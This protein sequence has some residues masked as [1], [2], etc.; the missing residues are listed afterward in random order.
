M[1]AQRSVRKV[2]GQLGK[3]DTLLFRWC[4]Q[5]NWRDR[6]ADYDAYRE[7]IARQQLEKEELQ[8]LEEFRKRQ[9]KLSSIATQSVI[10]LLTKTNERLNNIVSSDIPVTSLP[11]FF[12][13]AA[14]V[15]EAAANSE[16]A[17][18][19]VEELLR[20]VHVFSNSRKEET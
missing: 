1:G 7:R 10:A 9:K 4:Q 8:E 5:H 13:A 16:A 14:A 18:L 20:S 6:V 17:A 19:A 15:A 12:R 11:A 2:A 3:S